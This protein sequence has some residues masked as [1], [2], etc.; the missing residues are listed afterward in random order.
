MRQRERETIQNEIGR[1]NVS[2]LH[3]TLKRDDLC[4][5]LVAQYLSHDGY[6]ETAR[7]FAAEVR[8]ESTALKGAP[9]PKL[10]GFL[11]MEEDHDAA[12]R[13]R[14][15]RI[16]GILETYKLNKH[17]DTHSHSRWRHR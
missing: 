16:R 4:K 15:F 10:E 12:H 8:A 13:Q 14:K 6:I 11:S 7:A 1:A 3:P 9:E 17:R 2:T 5:A